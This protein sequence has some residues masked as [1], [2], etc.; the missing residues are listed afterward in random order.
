[1]QWLGFGVGTVVVILTALTVVFTLVVPRAR[2][3]PQRLSI[4]VNR[5]VR[6]TFLTV[7]RLASTFER[8]DSVLAAVGPIALL[9]Q[10]VVW[11]ACF[12]AG[13]ALMQWPFTGSLATAASS[14]GA[15]LFTVGIAGRAVGANS[16]VTVLSAATGAVV[17]ALQ[18]GYLPSIYSA[19]NKREVLVTLLESRAGIPSWGPEL[20]IR[21]QLV[22]ITDALP[23]LYEGWE[24]WAAEVSES[25]TTYPVLL[26]FR[27]PDAW[28]SWVVGLLAVL[29]AAALHL[30]LNPLTA[31]SQARLCLRMGFTTLRR[32]ANSM[33][34]QWDDDP[35]PE[36]PI[37]LSYEDFAEAV[38][39]LTDVRF[40]LERSAEEAWPHFRGWR[41][42]YEELAYHLA[43]HTVAPPAP[44]SGPRR[45]LRQHVVPPLRPPHRSPDGT[46]EAA[47]RPPGT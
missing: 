1:M 38:G 20:L 42:N 14:A 15:S 26:L 35:L 25:H 10:L 3:G 8:I 7:S 43:D 45:H 41:V 30:A 5:L 17:I 2:A 28:Y 16:L 4:M 31:P 23:D 12:F 47:R 36:T 29:D 33:N 32:I 34:W 19:F 40:P 21:H 27:S 13:F 6:G 11:L 37:D 44:W 22:G 18:I 39:M 46:V 24:Q 9:T